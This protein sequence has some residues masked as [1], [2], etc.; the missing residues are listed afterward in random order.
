LPKGRGVIGLDYEK[1]RRRECRGE[2]KVSFKI[3]VLLLKTNS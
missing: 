2:E 3:V 1:I